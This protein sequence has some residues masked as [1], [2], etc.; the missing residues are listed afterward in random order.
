MGHFTI[1]KADY[2]ELFKQGVANSSFISVVSSEDKSEIIISNNQPD[3]GS[4]S[5]VYKLIF[6]PVTKKIIQVPSTKTEI[7]EY[8]QTY[9]PKN[10]KK[11][12]CWNPS[13]ASS[14]SNAWRCMT[15]EFIHDPCFE[16]DSGQVVCGIDSEKEDAFE[17]KL[18]EPLPKQR[19]DNT[20]EPSYWKIELENG[21]NCYVFTGTAGNL[22]NEYVYHYCPPNGYLLSGMKIGEDGEDNTLNKKGEYWKV[23]MVV[24]LDDKGYSQ[25]LPVEEVNVIRVWK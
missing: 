9:I 13:I 15:D 22:N 20:R 16:T 25:T 3:H 14:G 11:G 7:I 5:I 12:K 24:D 10:S 1:K 8:K 2:P 21:L 18:T 17:L 4:Y 23:R 19:N 6:N